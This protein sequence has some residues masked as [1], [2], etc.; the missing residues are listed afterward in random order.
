MEFVQAAYNKEEHNHSEW[1]DERLQQR[2]ELLQNSIRSIGHAAVRLAEIN[3]ELDIIA[4]EQSE[5]VRH[6]RNEQIEEAWHIR[7][8]D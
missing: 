6:A 7:G 2:A 1:S 4:F 5:R 3:H 8:I